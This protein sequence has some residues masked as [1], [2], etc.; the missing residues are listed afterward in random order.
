M[1]ATREHIISLAD[2]LI[3][4]KGFNAFSYSDVAA[5]LNIRNA[6]IH[7]HFPVKSL[8]G[9]A[10]I[11]E[12][13]LR[14]EGYR[15]RNAGLCGDLQLRHLVETFYQN[16]QRGA[17]CLMGALTPEFATFDEDMQSM[18]QKLCV[19]IREWAAD[20]LEEARASGQMQF[21]G[22]ALDRAA[23]LVSTLL[24][25]LLLSR[26]EG[27]DLFRRMVDQMLEDLGAGWR[28]EDLQGIKN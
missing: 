23:L 3:R 17:V 10:V 2:N 8:L 16:S 13:L 18:L 28:T 9:Q 27:Q 21:A 26:I 1:S 11:Y 22:E 6:A 20:C 15:Y 12:E 7:Y 14:M 25:S 5:V 19:A 24:S 4:Q